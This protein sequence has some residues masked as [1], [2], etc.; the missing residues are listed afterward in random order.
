MNDLNISIEDKHTF[1]DIIPNNYVNNKIYLNLYFFLY[2]Y[3]IK[4]IN[5]KYTF[6]LYISVELN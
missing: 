3:I 5:Q 1:I 4:E 6:T 2:N